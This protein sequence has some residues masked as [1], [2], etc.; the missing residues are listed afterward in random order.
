MCFQSF[1]DKSRVN[2]VNSERQL[3]SKSRQCG[4]LR[5]GFLFSGITRKTKREERPPDRSLTMRRTLRH[6]PL[7]PIIPILSGFKYMA[8]SVV[9]LMSFSLNP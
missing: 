4:N 9:V 1:V 3:T 6:V 2:G 5:S 7:E 8:I